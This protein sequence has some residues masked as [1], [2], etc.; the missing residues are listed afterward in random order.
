MPQPFCVYTNIFTLEGQDPS[1][2]KYVD[3]FLIWL[4]YL[5]KYGRL[6]PADSLIVIGDE[7]T[8]DFISK[9][10][11][12]LYIINE[13][14]LIISKLQFIKYNPPKTIKEGIMK[15]YDLAD[16][17]NEPA[18]PFVLYLDVDTLVINNIHSLV[19]NTHNARTTIYINFEYGD[20]LGD[21]YAGKTVSDEERTWLT[22]MRHIIPF[23][24]GAGIF[25]WQN[26]A[27]IRKF[28]NYIR[29]RAAT[30]QE[31]LYTVEQPFFNA[32]IVKYIREADP[33]LAFS[34]LDE[35]HITFN[36]RVCDCG[37]DVIL[38]NFAGIPGDQ[39][40]HW[41]K[42]FAQACHTFLLGEGVRKE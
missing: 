38:A 9:Q 20:I 40:F 27:N 2:N 4:M 28:F 19:E 31:E 6:S 35:K 7:P 25:A 30:C 42:I 26:N 34:V 1:K 24:F 8:I 22:N 41:N 15:R 3:M 11:T 37:K 16:I 36:K 32:A 5:A 39:E 18:N 10:H 14:K 23:G 17:L 33:D 21:N 29:E 13:K 12:I